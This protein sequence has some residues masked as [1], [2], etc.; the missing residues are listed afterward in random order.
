MAYAKL[1]GSWC[2]YYSD[3]CLT[4]R[5]D[6]WFSVTVS[7]IMGLHLVDLDWFHGRVPGGGVVANM[8]I[9]LKSD[10]GLEIV[11]SSLNSFSKVHGKSFILRLTDDCS[12]N[13][14]S[15]SSNCSSLSLTD[16]CFASCVLKRV[17]S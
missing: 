7:K 3:R 4:D 17:I 10:S 16:E 6:L 1:L 9:S 2:A 5:E 8:A 14:S 12:V 11:D 15:L 13:G